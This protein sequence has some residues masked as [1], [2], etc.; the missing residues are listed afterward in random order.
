[1]ADPARSALPL[2]AFGHLPLGGP[3]SRVRSLSAAEAGELLAYERAHA[4]RLP[5]T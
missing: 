4:D 3:E 1:M 5:V 2:P